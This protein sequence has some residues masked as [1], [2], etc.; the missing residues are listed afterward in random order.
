MRDPWRHVESDDALA[1]DFLAATVE[2]VWEAGGWVHPDARLIERS[3]ELSLVCDAAESK[4]LVRLPRA[5]IVRIGRVAW[6][7][8]DDLLEVLDTPDDFSA[9]ERELLILQSGL[10]NACGKIPRLIS[11]HP[12]LAPD[13]TRDV[14][15]AVRAFRP[16]FRR[17]QP[18]PAGL[19]W[20]TR[21]FRLDVDGSG[22]PEPVA[23]PIVDLL[24]HDHRAGRGTW[25]GDSFDI[26]VSRPTG[27]GECFLDYGL[28]RDPIGVAVVYGFADTTSEVAHSA[29]L[30]V[31]VP[32]VGSVR[33]A[34][35]GRTRS[36]ELLPP[37]VSAEDHG[38]V[39]SHLTFR[40]GRH[41][42]LAAGLGEA[43]GWSR[44][45]CDSVI[46]AVAEANVRRLD[47][48]VAV[49]AH[50][51]A[52]PAARVLR[53]AA[54]RQRSVLVAVSSGAPTTESSSSSL[55]SGMT[56]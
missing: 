45:E 1:A 54:L 18:T 42:A 4:P 24:N 13:L 7:D 6:G 31:E 17:R 51:D 56:G 22:T 29:P 35:K 36:G 8:G 38:V 19:L 3:G 49:A 30:R 32:G 23:L 52:V 9:T 15:D 33:V 34:A 40:P 5:A 12:A 27:A 16:S 53:D 55:S 26:R 48:L 2:A 47:E 50:A 37:L 46:A 10:H 43:S 20:S 44:Q 21:S 41:A 28:E 14:I 11:A 39:V 25:S